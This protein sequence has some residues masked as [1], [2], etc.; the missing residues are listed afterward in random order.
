MNE[1]NKQIEKISNNKSNI[2]N[3]NVP[4]NNKEKLN[5]DKYLADNNSNKNAEN[6][7]VSGNK[8]SKVLNNNSVNQGKILYL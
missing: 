5:I 3:E 7:F 8:I 4:V 6:N 2:S 1:K